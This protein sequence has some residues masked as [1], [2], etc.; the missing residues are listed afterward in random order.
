MAV[1]LVSSTALA[2]R[3]ASPKVA[4]NASTLGGSLKGFAG[5]VE[6]TATDSIAS[7]YRL[8]TIPSNARVHQIL[9]GCDA[10]TSA[11]GDIG[12]YKGPSE[13]G[14]VVDADFFASA[15]ALTSALP[16]TDVT[17][18]SG[19]YGVEKVEQFLWQALGLTADPCL[20]Y[21]VAVTLTAAATGAG[22]LSLKGTYAL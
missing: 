6:L 3:E 17:H 16:A 11:I 15:Q 21:D 5:T 12:I 8:G 10:I 2:G 1:V 13:G 14:A 7:I 18:E 22:T 9:L 4:A 20:I 19:V